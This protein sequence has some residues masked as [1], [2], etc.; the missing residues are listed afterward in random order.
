MN[1]AY[2]QEKIYPADNKTK[3]WDIYKKQ[4][5]YKLAPVFAGGRILRNIKFLIFNCRYLNGNALRI[6]IYNK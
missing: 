4:T 6:L 3:Q 5:I 2:I 1:Y